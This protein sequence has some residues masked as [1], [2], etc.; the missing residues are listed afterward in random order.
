M[1]TL[2]K[3]CPEFKK[4]TKYILE[5]VIKIKCECGFSSIMN[6]N[7]I[8]ICQNENPLFK[9]ITKFRKRE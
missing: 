9:D 3:I 4:H 8:P 7:T 6:I 1:N 2:L 5:K